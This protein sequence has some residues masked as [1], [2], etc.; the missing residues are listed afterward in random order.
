MDFRIVHKRSLY[1]VPVLGLYLYA[2]GH[3]GIDRGNAFRARKGLQRAAARVARGPNVVVF[4]EG[5]RSP[6]SAV[7][8]FKRGSFVLALEAGVPVVPAVADRASRWLRAAACDVHAGTRAAPRP[9]AHPDRGPR[10]GG[11]GAPW[12]KRCG[13]S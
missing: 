9:P 10:R 7:G 4:P 12:P 2:S 6:E 13:R 5:T 1:L 8:P 3:I 11:G